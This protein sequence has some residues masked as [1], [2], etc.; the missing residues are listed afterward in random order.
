MSIRPYAPS[1]ACLVLAVYLHCSEDCIVHADTL[2]DCLRSKTTAHEQL[3]VQ[4]EI[5]FSSVIRWL[6]FQLNELVR[7]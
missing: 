4:R 7:A 2:N 6:A 5:D 1:H 3:M